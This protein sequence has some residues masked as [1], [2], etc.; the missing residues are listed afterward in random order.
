MVRPVQTGLRPDRTGS[1]PFRVRSVL[2]PCIL[3]AYSLHVTPIPQVVPTSTPVATNEL[4]GQ[5]PGR[6]ET[7]DPPGGFGIHFER[8][9][10]APAHNARP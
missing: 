2:S 3:A 8:E 5:S 10:N 6:P 1:D 9:E 4:I 7:P